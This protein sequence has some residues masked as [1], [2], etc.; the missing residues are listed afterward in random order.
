ME[1]VRGSRFGY[2]PGTQP[3]YDA[4][5]YGSTHKRH[6]QGGWCGC[7]IRLRKPA[8]R[9][10]P[11]H[12]FRRS[13]TSPWSTAK[14]HSASALSC[15]DGSPTRMAGRSRIRSSRSG[16]PTRRGAISI[17][18]TSTRRR[19]IRIFAAKAASTPTPTAGIGSPR[20]SPAPI[21]GVIITMPGARTISTSHFSAPAS[22]SAWSP[23][24]IFRAIRCSSSTRS[25]CRSPI[26]AARNRLVCRLDMTVTEPEWALGY[27]WDVVMRG[28]EATPMEG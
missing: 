24:C 19:R 10:F 26:E 23:K 5:A 20:S 7:R 14:R 6:P 16:R 22:P 4:P 12:N 3:P 25:F 27:R 2:Q 9:A 11:P 18:P 8:A 15:T 1:T 28:R 17:R 13:P 21:P